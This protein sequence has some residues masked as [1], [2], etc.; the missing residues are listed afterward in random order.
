RNTTLAG[1]RFDYHGTPG[2]IL[3]GRVIGLGL[4]LAYHYSFD[5]SLTL[6]LATIALLLL[7]LPLL[8]R[9]S[10]RFRLHNSSYRGLRFSFRGSVAD[11]YRVFAGYGL[12]AFLIAL[13][14]PLFHHR[15]KRYQH[16]NSWFGQTPGRFDA[17]YRDFAG[18]YVRAIGLM[19]L[20]IMTL[21]ALAAVLSASN[22]A[23]AGPIPNPMAILG[24]VYLVVVIGMVG[25]IQPYLSARLQN[26]IWNHTQLGEHRF[27]SR[28]SVRTLMGIQLGNLAL[29]LLTLGFYW[30]WAAVRLARYRLESVSLLPAG[31]LDAFIAAAEQDVA[32]VGDETAEWF[33]L[34]IAL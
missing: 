20:A 31:S 33:D 22:G 5:V 1:A 14:W 3:K 16:S 25:V 2:A 21:G 34:D 30:P 10:L 7:I 27:E 13:F 17:S 8:L 19:L 6:G 12:L 4:L 15:L 9:S 11:A 28:V 26:V 18:P 24:V 32:A 23:S 29:T